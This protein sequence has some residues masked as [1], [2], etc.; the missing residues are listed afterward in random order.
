MLIQVFGSKMVGVLKRVLAFA[1]GVG[2]ARAGVSESPLAVVMG[3]GET[4]LQIIDTARP[5]IPPA[6]NQPCIYPGH[7]FLTAIPKASA[8]THHTAGV[9]RGVSTGKC[10][11]TTLN[12]CTIVHLAAC[13]PDHAKLVARS[14]ALV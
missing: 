12:G 4:L 7:R 8:R 1:T 2:P 5:F 13:P 9:P 3:F 11:C 6:A 14:K 10:G